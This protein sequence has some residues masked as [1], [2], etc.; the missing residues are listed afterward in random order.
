MTSIIHKAAKPEDKEQKCS[1]CGIK[2]PKPN[3]LVKGSKNSFW[4]KNLYVGVL[5]CFNGKEI[6]GRTG[7]RIGANNQD[8]LCDGSLATT[9]KQ[10]SI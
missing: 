7:Y 10:K 1:L 6:M 4:A 5:T 3:Q 9:F 2:L 8:S